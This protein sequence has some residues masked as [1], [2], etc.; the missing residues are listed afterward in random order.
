[1]QQ[2]ADARI[3]R[4][5]R[6]GFAALLAV[7]S[8][9]SATRHVGAQTF[10]PTTTAE[11][12]SAIQTA[13]TM[14]G[15]HTIILV[16]G[17]VY[18][19][20][21]TNNG[22]SAT[23][24]ANGFPIITRDTDLTITGNGATIARDTTSGT[25]AFRFFVVS[26]GTLRLRDLT[27][28][29][30]LIRGKSGATSDLGTQ[31][32]VGGV[33]HGGAIYN[34]G[35]LDL[36]GVTLTANTATGGVGGMGGPSSGNTTGGNGGLGGTARGGAIYNSSAGIAT[37][38]NSTLVQNTATGGNGGD[39]GGSGG[40]QGM[41]GT[42][43]PA[44]GGAIYSERTLT[45]TNVTIARNGVAT[46]AYGQG[47]GNPIAQT[48]LG[49][50][51][52]VGTLFNPSTATLTNTLLAA[53]TAQTVTQ[54]TAS[55]C[56]GTAVTDGGHN[57]EPAPAITCGFTVTPQTG[58]PLLDSAGLK[59]NGGPTPTLAVPLRSPAVGN[60]DAT[61]CA[62]TFGAAVGGVDQRGFPRPAAGCAIGAF[63]P[64]PPP[65]ISGISP[66][67]GTTD[68]AARVTIS[69][70]GFMAGVSVG[71]GT[72]T[73]TLTSATA[74]ALTFAMPPHAVGAVTVR[75]TNPDGQSAAVGFT[76][77]TV[78][79]LPPPPP[80]GSPVTGAGSLPVSRP[81]GAPMG[82]PNSLPPRR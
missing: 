63:E 45:V 42:G 26:G 72:T 52:G 69:G 60:G 74:T 71:F 73:L 46:G 75:V 2:V 4:A 28:R 17:R 25:P 51:I 67:S 41:V 31:G 59:N 61:V 33:G 49:G 24:S 29:D 5:V 81:R 77:A 34:S 66:A 39:A 13:A 9:P 50:G 56:G 1:M 7:A 70:T 19:V 16:P 14:T 47:T 78:R 20:T 10:T 68:G 48:S 53:N 44:F 8:L 18:T 57:L 38:V 37:L 55:N 62:G 43:G 3:T 22:D 40:S 58:D 35:T 36:R 65:A 76:Y 27:L 64:Q 23:G 79:V 15:S 11:L 82:T 21:A 80:T 32:E 6:I 30:G 12:V 54:T